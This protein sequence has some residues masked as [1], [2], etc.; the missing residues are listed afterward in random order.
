MREREL[1]GYLCVLMAAFF[2]GLLGIMANLARSYGLGAYETSFM[3]LF[4]G[5]VILG[6]GMLLGKPQTFRVSRGGLL[7]C[8]IIGV[9]SQGLFNIFYFTS[10]IELGITAGVIMLYTSPAFTLIFSRIFQGTPLT[11]E[12]LLAIGVTFTG[13]ILTVSGGSFNINYSL[14]GIVA[15]FMAGATYGIL[16]VFNKMISSKVEV[17]TVMYYSFLAGLLVVTPLADVGRIYTSILSDYR[18]LLLGAA[19]G[20]LP[21]VASHFAFLEASKR[22]GSFEMSILANF[23]VVVAAA[24]A[25]LIYSEPLGGVRVAGILLVISGTLIPRLYKKNLKRAKK[26]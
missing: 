18:V 15:G 3:R 4:F 11:R 9:I 26:A 12:K 1:R 10:I 23:E 13:S 25:Y 24:T 6:G 17:I 7:F 16:P 14:I 20:F 2:W 22:L 19:L 21:T 8:G 5:M